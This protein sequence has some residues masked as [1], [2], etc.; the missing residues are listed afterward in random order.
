MKKLP[1]AKPIITSY[2][3]YANLI[4]I[5]QQHPSYKNAARQAKRRGLLLP[6][7]SA[8][9]GCYSIREA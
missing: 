1:I 7:T 2:P 8:Q 6:K 3:K 9:T 5:I 4:A